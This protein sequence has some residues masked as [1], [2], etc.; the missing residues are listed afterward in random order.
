M[1]TANIDRIRD[2][3]RAPA[4]EHALIPTCSALAR[5]CKL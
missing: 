1:P 4:V 3:Q 2:C 5:A